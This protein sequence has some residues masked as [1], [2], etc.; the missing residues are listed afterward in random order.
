[1]DFGVDFGVDVAADVW[2]CGFW[3]NSGAKFGACLG[4]SFRACLGGMLGD[5]FFK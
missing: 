5:I 3:G 1:M 2:M 4:Y